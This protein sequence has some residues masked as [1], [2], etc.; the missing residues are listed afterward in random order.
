MHATTSILYTYRMS[1]EIMGVYYLHVKVVDMKNLNE[2]NFFVIIS[3]LYFYIKKRVFM[4]ENLLQK[5]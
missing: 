1:F 5:K 4:V 2:T 3:G